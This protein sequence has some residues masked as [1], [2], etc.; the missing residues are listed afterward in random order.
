MNNEM[1]QAVMEKMS[2]AVVKMAARTAQMPNQCCPFF[3]G[4]PNSEMAL[5]SK[6]FREMASTLKN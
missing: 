5:R 6:D 3:L 4:K 2:K 1:K